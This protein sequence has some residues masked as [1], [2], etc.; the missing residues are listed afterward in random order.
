MASAKQASHSIR[1]M[2]C[3]GLT[4]IGCV[5]GAAAAADRGLATV[6]PFTV[7][8]DTIPAPLGNATGDAARGRS[9]IVARDAANCLL[10]HAVADP[11]VHYSGNVGP[12][13][14][15]V[16][17]RLTPAQLRLRVVDILRVNPDSIMPGYYRSEGL[18]RVAV[19]YRGKPILDAGQVEDIVAYLT[20]LQ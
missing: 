6:L 19:P 14:D 12:S 1:I 7:V 10:C 17:R 20:T 5:F 11:A 8:G 18:D 16:A 9:L 4:L 15:G 2:R 13:L 3:L